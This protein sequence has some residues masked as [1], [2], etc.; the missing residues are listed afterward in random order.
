MSG[1]GDGTQF[2]LL[3]PGEEL[4][5]ADLAAHY[6]YPEAYPDGLRR[7]WVRANMITSADGGAT[8]GGKSGELGGDGDRALFAALRELA[9]VI[10]VGAT[11]ARVENYSGV[12]LGAAARQARRHRGQSE[13]PPI[14]VLTRSGRLDHDAKLFDH[15]EVPPLILTSTR[16]AGDT[17]QRL[18][19]VA[20]VIDAS[21]ADSDS[22][23]PQAALAIL[24]ERGLLR[25]LAEGGPATLGLFSAHDLLDE[26]CLTVAPTLVGGTASRIV[27]GPADVRSALQLRHALTDAEGFLYL[28]YVRDGRGSA[29]AAG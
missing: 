5:S 28:R 23:D 22:V 2:T 19:R 14:A 6:T 11:T 1:D 18:G 24:S 13:V 16:A 7:C 10:V 15:S 20:E 3:G 25:V 12:Q 17:R 26:L 21:G 4:G 27:T 8:S 29:A 9:D